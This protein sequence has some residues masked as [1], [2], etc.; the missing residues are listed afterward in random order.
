MRDPHES[1][2]R[3]PGRS[4]TRLAALLLLLVGGA[5]MIGCRS[6]PKAEVEQR[7]V[8]LSKNAPAVEAGVRTLRFTFAP[9]EG[10]KPVEAE[11]SYV[12]FPARCDEASRG[13]PIVCVHPTPSSLFSFVEVA[14]GVGA[15]G[16][17]FRGLDEAH[18]VVLIDVVGHGVT[19][20]KLRSYDFQTC[21]RWVAAAIEA[22]G[23]EGV[24][25]IGN[26]YGGEFCWRAALDRPDLVSRL[27]LVDSS[28]YEREPDDFLSEEKA[29]RR[30]PGASL[31][32]VLNSRERVRNALA[33]HFRDLDEERLTEVFTT[34]EN[35]D[36]WGATVDLVRDEEGHRA[37]E[38]PQLGM[39]TLLVWGA[40]DLAFDVERYAR[41]FER[42][43]P[44]ARLVVF[45]ETGHY[46][47]EERPRRFAETVLEFLSE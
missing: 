42:D 27:V 41:R 21:A 1:A 6:L 34:L 37:G 5:A 7:L 38:L 8:G 4:R 3:G 30:L 26:S 35:A 44:N 11:L 9:S 13:V 39:P 17:R 46:P 43:I 22:L 15:D 18:D 25:L 14:S 10:A 16:E 28:G 2:R 29:M 33:P 31:G 45:D 12:R 47:Q 23:L 19:R 20:T 24:A 40:D 32:W 36:N